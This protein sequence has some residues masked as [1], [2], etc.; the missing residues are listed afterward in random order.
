MVDLMVVQQEFDERFGLLSPPKR[1]RGQQLVKELSK[2]SAP[3]SSRRALLNTVVGFLPILTWLPRYRWRTDLINDVIGGL[4][5]G[6]MHVP[7][8]KTPFH[9]FI[10]FHL[11]SVITV[12]SL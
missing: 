5:V 10:Q 8:G 12:Q 1:S 4:T 6:I 3:C 9:S 11:F 2:C 7:Q